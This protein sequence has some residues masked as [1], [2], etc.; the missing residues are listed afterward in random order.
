MYICK[1]KFCELLNL[2]HSCFA[3]QVYICK[4]KFCELDFFFFFFCGL[5]VVLPCRCTFAKQNFAN[6]IVVFLCRSGQWLN[7][8]CFSLQVYIRKAKFCELARD[9]PMNALTF[10][11]SDLSSVI[12]HEDSKEEKE[13]SSNWNTGQ[14]VRYSV[15]PVKVGGYPRAVWAM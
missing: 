12:N 1:A 3:L 13:V 6:L 5:I 2:Y 8:C 9:D 11:H 14:F 15:G 10:L 7:D 4:A